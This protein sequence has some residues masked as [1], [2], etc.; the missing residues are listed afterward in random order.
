MGHVNCL[1]YLVLLE[2]NTAA[3][4]TGPKISSTFEWPKAKNGRLKRELSDRLFEKWGLL[5]I[6]RWVQAL[7]SAWRNW[8]KHRQGF[9]G[10]AT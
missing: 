10:D 7:N 2:V 8:R 6:F 3:R 9:S 4:K 1:F 5:G